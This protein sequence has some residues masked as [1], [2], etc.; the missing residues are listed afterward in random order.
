M[1]FKQFKKS[2]V[3]GREVVEIVL[4]RKL[5]TRLYREMPLVL[6]EEGDK[7]FGQSWKGYWWRIT[8]YPPVIVN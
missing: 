6:N 2:Q 5:G 8:E 3:D 4:F 7:V 1:R